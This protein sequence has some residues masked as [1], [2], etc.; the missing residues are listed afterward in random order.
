MLDSRRSKLLQTDS[1]PEALPSSVI[2]PASRYR[3]ERVAADKP[4]NPAPTRIQSVQFRTSKGTLLWPHKIQAVALRHSCRH[5]ATTKHH[6]KRP[7]NGSNMTGPYIPSRQSNDA[8]IGV[9]AWVCR[10]LTGIADIGLVEGSNRRSERAS[11]GSPK[12]LSKL[13]PVS[14]LFPEGLLPN[15]SSWRNTELSLALCVSISNK[16]CEVSVIA[17]GGAR[18]FHAIDV[19]ELRLRD[20]IGVEQNARPTANNTV[21]FFCGPPLTGRIEDVDLFARVGRKSCR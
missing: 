3:I 10:R 1:R 19:L 16:L 14:D 15:W 18:D 5:A 13:I 6:R 9:S 21:C 4:F 8:A 12:R 17:R 2:G 7:D 11:R 20:S